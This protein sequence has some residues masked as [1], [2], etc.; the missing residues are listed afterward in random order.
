M[1]MAG[2]YVLA[3][4]LAGENDHRQAF[5]QYDAYVRPYA[6]KAQRS[7]VTQAKFIVGKSPLPYRLTNAFLRVLPE[8]LLMLL[9]TRVHTDAL[10]MPLD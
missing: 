6:A 8:P 1:A 9:L 2:A 4:K 10:E 3:K 5:A 7:A